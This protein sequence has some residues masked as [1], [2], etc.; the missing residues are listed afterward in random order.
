MT[1]PAGQGGGTGKP[2]KER[3][4][5]PGLRSTPALATLQAKPPA[6]RGLAARGQVR[7]LPRPGADRGRQ[8]QLLTRIGPRLD[9]ALRRAVAEALAA[10][11]CDDALIDGEIVV[12]ADNG[13]SSFSALQRRFPKATDALIFYAFDLLHLDGEDCAPSR[14]SPARSGCENCSA[15]TTRRGRCA[16]ASISSSPARP[17]CAMPAAWGWKASSPS[18]PTRP[19][20]AGAAATG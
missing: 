2:T 7:R 1:K 4:R 5:A 13:V 8:G 10:L 11:P 18:A 9:G 15:A 3:R 17:C 19:I 20:A 12:L 14:C 6:G 16:T